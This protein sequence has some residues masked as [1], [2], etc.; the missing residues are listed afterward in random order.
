MRAL[1]WAS[2][3]RRLI[4]VTVAAAGALASSKFEYLDMD[5]SVEDFLK[6]ID[7]INQVDNDL[8]SIESHVPSGHC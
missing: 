8:R 1:R 7:N 3:P 2:V 5:W 4:F 6:H